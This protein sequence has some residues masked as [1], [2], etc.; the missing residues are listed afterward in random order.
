[1]PPDAPGAL[2]P[3][4]SLPFVNLQELSLSSV[5]M[6]ASNLTF[7]GNS[8]LKLQS[9]GLEACDVHGL[10]SLWTEHPDPV[11]MLVGGHASQLCN[12]SLA[13]N[14]FAQG[15]LY[16]DPED[17]VESSINIALHQVTSLKVGFVYGKVRLCLRQAS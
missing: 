4:L 1:M 13:C 14:R 3:V 5:T 2:L 9:L 8:R 12:L 7:I 6:H 11:A 17:L 15:V 10:G 16:D